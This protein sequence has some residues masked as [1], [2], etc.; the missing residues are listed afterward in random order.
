MHNGDGAFAA[1]FFRGLNGICFNKCHN[2]LSFSFGRYFG[3]I[4]YALI[5]AFI[6]A[7]VY[8]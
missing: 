8:K 3:R 5:L 4:V 1:G 7:E 2:K 6:A